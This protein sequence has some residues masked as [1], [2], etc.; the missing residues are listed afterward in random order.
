MDGFIVRYRRYDDADDNNYKRQTV[1][2]SSADHAVLRQLRSGTTYSIMVHSFNRHGESELSNT[3]AMTTL[4]S[5]DDRLG[6]SSLLLLLHQLLRYH[7][8]HQHLTGRYN[9]LLL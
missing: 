6:K 5:A 2:G 4:S 3:V 1:T 8:W 7:H 9:K